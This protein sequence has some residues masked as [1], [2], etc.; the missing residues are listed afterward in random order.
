[1]LKYILSEYNRGCKQVWRTGPVDVP[2]G[3]LVSYRDRLIN[4]GGRGR[5]PCH[6]AMRQ[7][8]VAGSYSSG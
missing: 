3:R 4:T 1:M 7:T 6:A 8:G 5:A 2:K